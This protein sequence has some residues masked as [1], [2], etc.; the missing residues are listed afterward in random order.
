MKVVNLGSL[1]RPLALWGCLLACSCLAG[2]N[3]VASDT[4][5]AG[6]NSGVDGGGG[7]TA[8]DPNAASIVAGQGVPIAVTPFAAISAQASIRKVKMLLTGDAVSEQEYAALAQDFNSM[9]GLVDDWIATPAYRAVMLRF[10]SDAFQQNLAQPSD[11]QAVNAYW[12]LYHN[13]E[14][15]YNFRDSFARTAM[16]FVEADT[17]F[18]QVATTR[19]FMMTTNMMAVLAMND[20]EPIT[21]TGDF[22]N[23]WMEKY[24]KL[25]VTIQDQKQISTS[26]SSNPNSANFGIFY[27]PGLSASAAT[28]NANCLPY[29]GQVQYPPQGLASG[30]TWYLYLAWTD[31]AWTYT[32]KNG[33]QCT[34]KTTTP[35]AGDRSNDS[36]DWRM[37][38][39]RLPQ[40]T[41]RPDTLFVWDKLRTSNELILSLPRVGYFTTAP[42]LATWQTNVSNQSRVTVNQAMIVGLGQAFDGSNGTQANSLPGLDPTHSDPTTPCYSCHRNMDPMRQFF[43]QEFD[44]YW[45]PQALSPEQPAVR[46]TFSFNSPPVGGNSIYDLGTQIATNPGFAAA[47]TQ[48]LCAWANSTPCVESDPEFL[49]VAD[50]FAKS[51]FSWNTLVRTLMASKL[52]TYAQTSPSALAS[53]GLIALSRRDHL[54]QALNQRLKLADLCGQ[55]TQLGTSTA[56]PLTSAL[57]ADGVTR[58]APLP[59]LATAASV[60]HR[61]TLEN[62]CAMA[63]NQAVDSAALPALSSANPNQALNFLVQELMGVS[64]EEAAPPLAV[65][66]KHFSAALA[67]SAAE[68]NPN[69]VALKS[70]FMLACM[71]PLV[72]AIGF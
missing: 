37:V 50:T 71:S 60:T 53:G 8:L 3:L 19:S 5:E 9:S 32:G 45:G 36:N 58:G 44:N 18:T 39:V 17:P 13:F 15:H 24:P 59:S 31:G 41:E 33:Y 47:W 11:Y 10:F 4:D 1:L 57:P 35:M 34:V 66:N 7:S 56:S 68:S 46:A 70:T 43:R 62:V 61:M 2:E 12:L 26:D 40:A 69:S 20:M 42:F 22:R 30:W 6:V 23:G 48:K 51:N 21:D 49:R 55:A 54:C 67:A 65:L 25:V 72:S 38:N 16:T 27:Q 63:G 52:I 14:G 28:L 64:Q 29:P